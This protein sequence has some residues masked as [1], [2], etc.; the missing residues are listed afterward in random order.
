MKSKLLTTAAMCGMIVLIL[1][2]TSCKVDEDQMKEIAKNAGLFSSTTWI[3]IDNPNSNV[4]STVTDIMVTVKEKASS[5]QSGQTYIQVV[6]PELVKIIDANV[7][8]Q[9]RPICKAGTFTLLGQLDLLLATHPEW[10]EN[11]DK[12][13]EVS[14]AFIDGSVQG[15]SMAEISSIMKQLN[16]NCGIHK[17]IISKK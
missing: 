3:A 10:K 5:V 2:L 13:I 12:A 17:E 7:E 1:G 6:Y 4:I 15:L 9:Y 16:I 11:Q 14:N 8:Q